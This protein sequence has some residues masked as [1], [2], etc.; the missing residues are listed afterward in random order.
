MCTAGRGDL[1]KALI[2]AMHEE[3]SKHGATFVLVTQIKELHEASLEKQILSLDV[4]GPLANH[5]FSLPDNLKHINESGNGVLAWEIAEFL[6][7]NQLIPIEHLN[8]QKP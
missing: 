3:S 8:D 2:F 4:S 6:Q 1:G 5:K 7:T